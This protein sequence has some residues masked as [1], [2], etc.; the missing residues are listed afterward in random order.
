M[1][2]PSDFIMSDMFTHVA[3]IAVGVLVTLMVVGAYNNATASPMVS[4][5]K[6]ATVTA[7]TAAK[8]NNDTQKKKNRN[9]KN[10][11]KPVTANVVV[12]AAATVETEEEEEEDAPTPTPLPTSPPPAAFQ[13]QAF[14]EA[15]LDVLEEEEE[16][17]KKKATKKKKQ[18]KKKNNSATNGNSSAAP[19][20]AAAAD[21][22]VT[23]LATQPTPFVPTPFV[24]PLQARIVEEEAWASVPI[25]KKK[26]KVRRDTTAMG[27]LGG[28]G[29]ANG[30]AAP[31]II[32]KETVTI[33]GSRVGIIIGPKGATML[34]IQ[35]R[36]GCKLDVNAPKQEENGG[37]GNQFR[38]VTG[39]K[40]T[41]V[42]ATVVITEGTNEGRVLAKKAILE[43]ADRGYAALLQ[44]DQ[45]GEASISVHPKYM[46]EIVGSGGKIIKAIQSELQVKITIPKTDWTPKQLQIGNIQPTCRVGIAGDDP[47]NVKTAKQVIKDICNYH[48]HEITHPG[49]SHEEVYV[50]QEFFHCVI[51]PRGSEIKH[52]RGNYKVDVYIPSS[53]SVTENVVCVGRPQDVEKAINYIKL[54]MDRDSELREEKYSDERYGD[55]SGDLEGW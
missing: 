37:G 47:R 14:S 12:A 38:P 44:G 3:A 31:V 35:E 2:K 50:P 22:T 36:T 46:S 10:K 15:E 53:D 4:S 52:I 26:K 1:W 24:Q 41:K 29:G 13:A 27:A 30:T 45:F 8:N 34:A 42:T 11:K 23:L 25:Q 51:G 55:D 7:T 32:P 33:D 49:F 40:K 54:L 39:G 9:K 28:G 6:K 19:V 18:K 16:K 5:K 17:K 21:D 48:H 43:L 20:V